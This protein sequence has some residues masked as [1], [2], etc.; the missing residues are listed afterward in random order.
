METDLTI[1]VIGGGV[2]GNATAKAFSGHASVRVFDQI[3]DRATH[4]LEDTLACSI[5]FVCL[6]E[7]C[8]DEFFSPHRGS[9]KNFVLKSTVPVGTTRRLSKIYDIDS[10][11]HSPEFLTERTAAEDAANPRL[12]VIGIPV[13]SDEIDR[14]VPPITGL[15]GLY[16]IRWPTVPV[17]VMSSDESELVKLA[18]N[19]FFATKVA[20]WNEVESYCRAA[21][22]DYETVRAA[23]VAEGRVGDLHTHVPGPDGKRGFGGKCLPKDLRQLVRCLT[24]AGV[25]APVMTAVRQ[26]NERLDRGT[27]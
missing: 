25:P 11:V 19:A 7:T 14:Q 2:V 26:R 9:K 1:G 15:E 10:L 16:N 27:E 8:I 3:E 24:E 22:I 20:F 6:P 5:I 23:C 12:N 4:A 13:K 18:T 17:R 21:G